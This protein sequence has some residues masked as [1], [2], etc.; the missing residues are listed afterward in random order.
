MTQRS[1]LTTLYLVLHRHKKMSRKTGS[2]PNILDRKIASKITF[3]DMAM[4]NYPPYKVGCIFLKH[5][6]NCTLPVVEFL[7]PS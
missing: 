6:L 5:V 3:T 2:F 7:L 1:E 4:T